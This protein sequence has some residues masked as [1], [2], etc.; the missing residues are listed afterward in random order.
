MWR[1]R[2][3]FRW[4]ARMNT[5]ARCAMG[6]VV[7]FSLMF[8]MA[9]L[10]AAQQAQLPTEPEALVAALATA[11]FDE[12][13]QIVNALAA[14]GHPRAI[15][16][17]NA[18][19]AGTISSAPDGK[20]VIESGDDAKTYVDALSG[21]PVAGLT[22]DQV[23]KIGVNNRLRRDLRGL[24]AR[25]SL[26]SRD[27]GIRFKAAADAFTAHDPETLPFIE[28]ALKQETVAGIRDLLEQTRSAIALQQ[29]D[30]S[31]ADKIAAI[32]ALQTRG[33]RDALN[34][35][36]GTEESGSEPVRA[37]AAA[38]VESIQASLAS[39]GVL[40]NVY[41]GLSLGSV[42]L[43]AA[44]GLAVTFG[45]M[46]V[47]NMAHGEMIMLGAYTAYVV[48]Q[49]LAATAPSLMEISLLIAVPSAF[50]VAATAGILIERGIIRFLYGRPLETLLATWGIS[51]FLQQGVRTIFGPT[52]KPVYAPSWMSG[53]FEIGHLTIT[54]SRLWIIV[55]AMASLALLM[56]FL[57]YTH[58]GMQMRAVT[59]NR[60]MASAMGVRTNWVDA[61][62]FGLGSGVAGIAGV[63]LS[64]IDNVSPNLG[65]TYIIDSFMVV[66]FG[67][68]GNLWG[69]L[70]GSMTL[71]VANKLLEPYA[72]AVVGKILILVC[73]ILFIQRRPRGLFALRGRAVEA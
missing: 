22:E 35:L 25:L 62:T 24:S 61:L 45:V 11:D 71:G 40:Q 53:A 15:A 10:A 63:A 1:A 17:I 72:G 37:A 12:K 73:I 6:L 49:V 9:G 48:Q 30:T 52:N 32:A 4:G 70:V 18:L 3:F 2:H 58:F 8:A 23:S 56:A 59:Q 66:V 39:W 38:A 41:Y 54:Y 68:V 36:L 7:L 43:L 50:A 13:A 57:K 34:I 31:D 5:V 46:G 29:S 69:T 65:Q 20:I 55:F 44:T 26:M 51:L 47:I 19:T 16:I 14:S 64:Q 42:L 67:G 28:E 60:K 21:D 33:D 27:R